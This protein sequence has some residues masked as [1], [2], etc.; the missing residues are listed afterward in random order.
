MRTWPHESWILT[1]LISIRQQGTT[2]SCVTL[3]SDTFISIRW[4]WLA[5]LACQVALSMAFVLCVAVQTSVWGVAVTKRHA[6]ATLLAVGSEDTA[7]LERHYGLQGYSK[8]DVKSKV[9]GL[10]GRFGALSEG[11]EWVIILGDR[12]KDG[13]DARGGN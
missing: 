6:L 11:K 3:A 9:G 13:R 5:F 4:G 2:C 10:T 12:H 8:A 1:N 7:V